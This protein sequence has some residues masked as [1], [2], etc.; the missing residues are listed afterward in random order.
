MTEPTTPEGETVARL[1]EAMA[2]VQEST[3]TGPMVEISPV[4]KLAGWVLGSFVIA[5]LGG[6]GVAW[7]QHCYRWTMELLGG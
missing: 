4:K 2:H 3:H 7:A 6:V 1:Q 5:T